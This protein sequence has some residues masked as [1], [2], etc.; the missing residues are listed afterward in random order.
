[1][2][3]DQAPPYPNL[4]ELEFLPNE[5]VELSQPKINQAIQVSQSI[6]NPRRRWQTYLHALALFG[7][8]EWLVGWAPS[9]DIND[10]HC[11][12]LQP[13]YANWVEAAC[14]LHVGSF[15]LCLLTTGSLMDS[16]ISLPRAAIDLPS[17][18]PHLYVLVEVLEEE[19]QVQIYGYLRYDQLMQQQQSNPL[20]LLSNWTYGLPLDW[21]T[22]DSDALLLDL[23][24]LRP[25]AI[26][27]PAIAEQPSQADP[28]AIATPS[29]PVSLMTDG[30]LRSR[31]THL[32]PQLRRSDTL[33]EQ[34]LNWDEGVALLSQPDLVAWLHQE[35]QT[36]ASTSPSSLLQTLAQPVINVGHWLRDQLDSVAQELSWVLMPPRNFALRSIPSRSY[37]GEEFE[38]VAS[39]MERQGITIPSE[40][41]GAY[42]DFYWDGPPL[43]L[44]VVTWKLLS[45]FEAPEWTLLLL[46]GTQTG[47]EMPTGIR[48]QIQDVSQ[49]L[50]ERI[51]DES[52]Q[53]SYLCMQ[54]I[55]AWNEQFQVTI[56]LTDG[57]IITPPPFAFSSPE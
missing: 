9:L 18:I 17:F 56:E 31:L 35:L 57:V 42:H 8:E 2:M 45:T 20:K 39:A 43:R 36:T 54:V 33:P 48:L 15:N 11:S 19:M 34:L 49:V 1:M 13:Q 26:S 28:S 41:R 10:T 4:T 50:E 47:I 29:T 55:G 23:K 46:L 44:H 40:A 27:L 24:C 22:L 12:I 52:T 3:S 14:N 16:V 38:Q 25:D 53:H 51:S 21:F 30:Q 32:L 37:P 7:F 5:G 6:P